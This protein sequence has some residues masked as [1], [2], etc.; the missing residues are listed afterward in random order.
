MPAYNKIIWYSGHAFVVSRSGYIAQIHP[1]PQINGSDENERWR[2]ADRYKLSRWRARRHNI[3]QDDGV[4]NVFS[5][6]ILIGII[7]LCERVV[8]F[9]VADKNNQPGNC[10]E[11]SN[12]QSHTTTTTTTNTHKGANYT[13]LPIF[14]AIWVQHNMRYYSDILAANLRKLC[15]Q[16][17]RQRARESQRDLLTT[18]RPSVYIP[19][20]ILHSGVCTIIHPMC[21][22]ECVY[23]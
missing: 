2:T 7:Y 15:T 19:N 13:F 22:C 21:V 5:S 18:S 11:I 6:L 10:N 12:K 17:F 4:L 9:C 16:L 1:D 14:P 23:K 20:G 3:G 8:F